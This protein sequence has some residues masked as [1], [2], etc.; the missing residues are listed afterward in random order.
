M[1]NQIAAQVRQHRVSLHVQGAPQVANRYGTG[2]IS[3]T[4]IELTYWVD[5][6]EPTVG[7]RLFGTWVRDSGE[8]TDQICE[9]DYHGPQHNWPEWLTD[10]ARQHQPKP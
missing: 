4:R 9:Q 5:N 3:P 10:L 7:V 2:R 8:H 1:K 6:S